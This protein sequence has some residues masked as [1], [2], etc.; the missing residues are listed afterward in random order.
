LA[1]DAAP[2]LG[3]RAQTLARLFGGSAT[4]MADHDPQHLLATQ[5]YSSVSG[6]FVAGDA[7]RRHVRLLTR[8]VQAAIGAG[9]G[10][11]AAVFDGGHSWRFAALSLRALF[12]TIA[13]DVGLPPS[14]S[15]ATLV[16][17][18]TRAGGQAGP[19]PA[20]HARG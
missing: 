9:I 4:A 1:G 12:P 13:A 11:H 6:W 2:N 14:A 20:R 15:P 16:A 3:A 7:D 19:R 17:A 8:E 5:R 18:V 10:A